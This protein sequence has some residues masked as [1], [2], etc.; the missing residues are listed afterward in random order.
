[1]SKEQTPLK[2]RLS[3]VLKANE[4]I[5]AEVEDA[6][7]WQRVL[8]L[9]DTGKSDTIAGRAAHE[10]EVRSVPSDEARPAFR[11][12]ASGNQDADAINGLA[13]Q[14][15]LAPE[16]VA[17]ALS[18]ST[19]APYLHLDLHCWEALRSQLPARGRGAVAPVALAA[20]L[21]AL[22]FRHAGIGN[23]TQSEALSV[24]GTIGLRDQNASRGLKASSWLQSRGG[25]KIVL[26]PAEIS[27]ATKIAKSFCSKQWGG[28]SRTPIPGR[29]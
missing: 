24:L 2:A 13:Q 19:E 26:N 22:W 29:D 1:V 14:L 8:S 9:I 23:P 20:T 21:L 10:A 16:V 11:A 6:Q 7:L 5:V 15:G 3:V 28:E 12:G 18:P 4:V 27:K 17:G 25:G